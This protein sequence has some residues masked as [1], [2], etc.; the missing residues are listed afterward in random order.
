M[1]TACPRLGGLKACSGRP[2]RCGDQVRR[3]YAAYPA[4]PRE[5]DRSAFL[6][7]IRAAVSFTLPS[8]NTAA[9]HRTGEH[10]RTQ[11]FK[12]RTSS[13]L[14]IVGLGI[15]LPWATGITPAHAQEAHLVVD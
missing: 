6:S 8:S 9:F 5:V 3:A 15:V 2:N 4:T 12:R 1:R 14:T 13:L 10:M 7:R 11:G